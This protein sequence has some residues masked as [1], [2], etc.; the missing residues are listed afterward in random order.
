V[1]RR[2][3]LHQQRDNDLRLGRLDSSSDGLRANATAERPSFTSPHGDENQPL[4]PK[5]RRPGA[6]VALTVSLAEATTATVGSLS[7]GGR[8]FSTGDSS[9]LRTARPSPRWRTESCTLARQHQF[10]FPHMAGGRLLRRAR[11]CPSPPNARG[12]SDLLAHVGGGTPAQ[13]ALRH[14][15]DDEHP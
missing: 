9:R 13:L 14:N 6:Q 2:R 1:T 8:R 11:G 7:S 3:P 5:S 10:T 4:K 15:E 12:R